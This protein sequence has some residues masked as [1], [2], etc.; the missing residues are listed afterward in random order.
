MRGKDFFKAVLALAG[1][2][3]L[4]YITGGR[5]PYFIFY[6]CLG[7][8]SVD[9][10]W[11]MIGARIT[12][13]SWV[14]TYSVQAG[15]KVRVFT[16]V[17]N[18]S[19]WPLP[20]VQCWID[21]PGTFGLPDNMCCY[22]F[23]LGPYETKVV[24]EEMECRIRGRFQWGECFI[25]TG[26]LLGFFTNT[27]MGGQHIEIEVIPKFFNISGLGIGKSR[28]PGKLIGSL[29]SVQENTGLFGIR[30][31]TSADGIS[32]IHWKI[33]AKSRQLMV[34]E[35]K[36]ISTTDYMLIL[37]N[38]RENH[39]GDGPDASFE[40]AVSLAASAAVSAFKKG[41]GISLTLY[42]P[43]ASF[44]N[45]SVK[46]GCG[47]SSLPAILRVLTAVELKDNISAEMASAID[48]VRVRGSRLVWITGN[49]DPKTV[50][51]LLREKNRDSIVFLLELETFGKAGVNLTERRKAVQRLRGLGIRVI[52]VHK[53]TDLRLMLGRSL[54]GIV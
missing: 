51:A 9:L 44:L 47:R 38:C 37:D 1:A 45:T 21:M 30:D 24:T 28:G 26:G 12:A 35:D 5:I 33:S 4:S 36:Q 11:A 43:D 19:G 23:S 18:N 10:I 22:N 6:T 7:I 13:S 49:L 25:R 27:R 52:T 40:R 3:I 50:E 34:K 17:R 2:Y 16:E 48:L 41:N 14:E 31:Y 8:L 53:D 42:R 54:Y 20:W 15:A 29:R 39:V 46:I 32:R